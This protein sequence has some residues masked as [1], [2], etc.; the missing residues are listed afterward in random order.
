MKD[1]PIRRRTEPRSLYRIL[2]VLVLAV[3]SLLVLVRSTGSPEW[4]ASLSPKATIAPTQTS[5]AEATHTALPTRMATVTSTLT[6]TPTATPSPTCTPTSLPPL[7]AIDAGHGGRD[8]GG[9]HFDADGHMDLSEKE[10]NLAIVLKIAGRVRSAGYRVL[11][12]RDGDYRINSDQRLDLNEDGEVDS[13]DEVLARTE[14]VNE[15]GA[16]LLLSIHQNAYYGEDAQDVAGTQTLYCADRPFSDDSYRFASLVHENL[17]TA[18]RKVGYETRDRGVMC[19]ADLKVPGAKGTYLI[20]LGPQT[21]RISIPSKMPGVLSETLFVTNDAEAEL[22][23]RA[24]VLDALAD[25]YARA[26]AAYFKEQ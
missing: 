14:L 19:D 9:R 18:L 12:T 2:A 8:F 15:A 23:Q 20:L 4:T 10:A 6:S 3:V 17:L 5:P 21:E 25:A 26:V 1:L 11:L 22:L 13:V 7:V 16:D 24:D